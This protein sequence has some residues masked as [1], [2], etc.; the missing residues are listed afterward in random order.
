MPY[1]ETSATL[2]TTL[3]SHFEDFTP[4][5][6]ASYESSTQCTILF[7][8]EILCRPYH[9]TMK[10]LNKL[11]AY[12]AT[13]LTDLPKFKHYNSM[14]LNRAVVSHYRSC[15]DRELESF[16]YSADSTLLTSLFAVDNNYIH[17]YIHHAHK[18]VKLHLHKVSSYK[19]LID[20]KVY[21]QFVDPTFSDTIDMYTAVYKATEHF[22][23]LKSLKEAHALLSIQQKEDANNLFLGNTSATIRCLKEI[24]TFPRTID[25]VDIPTITIT[26]PLSD[27][28]ACNARRKDQRDS[29]LPESCYNPHTICNY[30]SIF[31]I[32]PVYREEMFKSATENFLPIATELAESSKLCMDHTTSADRKSVV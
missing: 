32:R 23:Q 27:P 8:C 13:T 16:I 17:D 11:H 31:P 19:S 10:L 3:E 30:C 12:H 24:A 26:E 9:S 6:Y 1:S 7:D 21:L 5:E 22:K 29:G 2:S 15:I 25:T 28:V 4:S 18:F 20:F 14:V